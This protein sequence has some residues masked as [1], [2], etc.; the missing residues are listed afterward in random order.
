MK[1]TLFATLALAIT[2]TLI[3]APQT[4]KQPDKAAAKDTKATEIKAGAK[5]ADAKADAK[6]TDV[7][8][9]AKDAKK[10][11]KKGKGK[12]AKTTDKDKAPAPAAK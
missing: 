3:A 11:G 4:P 10:G 6:T 12:G 7:K 9:D 2:S 5:G 8:G 1:K